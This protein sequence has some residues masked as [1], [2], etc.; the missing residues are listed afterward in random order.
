MGLE[1]SKC[2]GSIYVSHAKWRGYIYHKICLI[3]L[4]D[5]NVKNQ[6]KR[7][8]IFAQLEISPEEVA[9]TLALQ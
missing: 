4:L 1:C 3:K 8:D 7:E 9:K 5:K 6:K 2:K